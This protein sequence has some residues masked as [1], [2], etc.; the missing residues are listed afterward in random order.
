MTLEEQLD[1]F[2]RRAEQAYAR[3]LRHLK[4]PDYKRQVLRMARVRLAEG[5]ETYGDLMF[6]WSHQRLT[7]E[8]LQE[9]A[10]AI[11]YR[12]ARIHRGWP[13]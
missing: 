11:N 10:D 8:E 12:L 3:H 2:D 6:T 5:F 4:D 9:D 7:D 13:T 1:L